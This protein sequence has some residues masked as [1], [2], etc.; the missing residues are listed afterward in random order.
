MKWAYPFFLNKRK[1]EGVHKI[2]S[3]RGILGL[4]FRGGPRAHVWHSYS[5]GRIV[6]ITS[7]AIND[8]RNAVAR[9]QQTNAAAAAAAAT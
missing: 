1:K 7:G 6:R 2:L 8:G 4:T 5:R 3:M 9:G